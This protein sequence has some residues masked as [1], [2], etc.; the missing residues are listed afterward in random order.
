MLVSL[1]ACLL[2]GS[3]VVNPLG[4]ARSKHKQCGIQ[5]ATLSLPPEERFTADNIF[6]VGLARAIG[7]VTVDILF[8]LRARG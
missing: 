5:M 2:L 4:V 7:G 3:Q 8:E 1:L 6:L